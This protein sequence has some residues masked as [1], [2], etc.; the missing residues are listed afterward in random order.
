MSM[1]ARSA[2]T[3][4]QQAGYTTASDFDHGVIAFIAD[5]REESIYTLLEESRQESKLDHH[6]QLRTGMKPCD[7]GR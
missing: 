5:D 2:Q 4:H 6:L 7:D 1:M 3:L